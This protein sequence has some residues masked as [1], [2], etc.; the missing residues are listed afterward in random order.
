MPGYFFFFLSYEG[1]RS[2]CCNLL[3]PSGETRSP[4]QLSPLE[5]MACGGMAGLAF[6]TAVFPMDV[7]KSR[8]QVSQDVVFQQTF[9]F[10]LLLYC[11]CMTAEEVS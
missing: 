11:R 9:V 8:I 7:I 6:W 3:T 5:T 2:L 10:L 1:S 4:S